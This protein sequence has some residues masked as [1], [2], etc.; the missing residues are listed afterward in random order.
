MPS[1]GI[2]PRQ[3]R[4][5][6]LFQPKAIVHPLLPFVVDNSET[7]FQ[8]VPRQPVNVAKPLSLDGTK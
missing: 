2:A 5:G 4:L 3:K 1:F 6:L 8:S 7:I